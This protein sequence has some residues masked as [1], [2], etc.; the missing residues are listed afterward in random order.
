MNIG[1]NTFGLG[2]CLCNDAESVWKDLWDAGVRSIE[3]CIALRPM[4]LSVRVFR[5]RL[6]GGIFSGADKGGSVIADLRRRGFDVYSFQL[7][8]ASFT[9]KNIADALP[10]MEEN[11]LKYLVYSFMKSD[12]SEIISMENDIREA[13]ALV[14]NSGKELLIHNHDMEWK[15]NNGTSVMRWLLENVPDLNF[16]LDLGWAE[17]AGVDTVSLLK[18]YPGRFPVLHIKEIAK[19]ARAWAGKP[20]CTAPGRG[21]LPFAALMQRIKTMDITDRSLIIDQD[22][23]IGGDI[24]SDIA[25]GVRKINSYF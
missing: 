1:I 22:D 25:E 24:I 23:S 14:K 9:V 13:A 8:N 7:Q 21:I 17:Y 3:P 2:P 19:G 12:V 4:P 20:I 11:D 16:E 5:K 15:E 10:F 18:E 6:F